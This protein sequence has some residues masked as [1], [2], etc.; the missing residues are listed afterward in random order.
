MFEFIGLGQGMRN[1]WITHSHN[2]IGKWLSD[3]DD[4]CDDDEVDIGGVA[5]DESYEKK[6]ED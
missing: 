6:G 5:V 3:A 1:S 2:E 4:V